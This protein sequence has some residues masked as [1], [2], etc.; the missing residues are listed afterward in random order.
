M[1]QS[2]LRQLLLY[3]YRYIIGFIAF[4]CMALFL[5]IV[6]LDLAPTGISEA[7]MNSAVS[8][9]TIKLSQPLAQSF[10]DAPYHILQKASLSLLNITELGIRL[11]SII[12]S[13]A[14]AMAFIY[15][16]RRWFRMNVAL[17]TSFILITSS[18]FLTMARTG[19]P[20]IMTTFW[21]SIILLAVTNIIH[22][23]G[24]SKLWLIVLLV[25]TPLSL[26]TP[27]MMYPLLAVGIA[28]LL[29]PHIRYIAKRTNT[30]KYIAAVAG[31]I[32]LLTPLIMTVIQ[33]PGRIKELTGIPLQAPTPGQLVTNTKF[34]LKSFLS[35]GSAVVGA[36]PQP[37]F[38]AATLII[39][40]LGFLR[41][42][43]DHYSAR[44]YML[45]IWTV[46]FIPLAL[47]N[48][49]KL[50][51]CLVPAYL[52]A[53]IG[54]ESLIREWYKLF[55]LNPYARLVGLIPLIIL[56]AGIMV[57]NTAQYF[58]GYFYGRPVV[59][60]NQQLEAS[61]ELL[62]T[63]AKNAPATLVVR[64]N[65]YRFYDLLRRD[66]NRLTVTPSLNDKPRQFT[67]VH[68][69][70]AYNIAS[71][72]TPKRIITS[73]KKASDQVILRTFAP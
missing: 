46:F 42:L 18:A 70:A 30:W 25:A 48:P 21:L 4:I 1:K 68:D 34:V 69:G 65:E 57:S 63:S 3:R 11:P 52:F 67:I 50:L 37:I 59:R 33:E 17:I 49:D 73:Y 19:T 35:I 5:M 24:K 6:R 61:R 9:A 45:I 36:I 7:E 27:L 58:Y 40:A 38:G 10:I 16:V 23:E 51:I 26:Y 39:I 47:L 53:A 20:M 41:V 13:V 55:P 8:S 66:Y 32:I 28:G 44:S 22:P 43:A 64:Q 14:T 2:L 29:H 56:L 12:L 31:I 71:S 60:Y 72:G 54:I 62:D 15:M